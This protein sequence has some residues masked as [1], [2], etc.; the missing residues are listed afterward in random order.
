M[1]QTQYQPRYL[2]VMTTRSSHGKSITNSSAHSQLLVEPVLMPSLS[3]VNIDPPNEAKQTCLFYPTGEKNTNLR[4]EIEQTV[5]KHNKLIE[6]S[7]EGKGRKIKNKYRK[8]QEDKYVNAKGSPLFYVKSQDRDA[9]SLIRSMRETSGKVASTVQ[10][11][12]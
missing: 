2:D 7:F 6:A 11:R 4:K 9:E 10:L 5:I 12:L 1:T 8:P 3:H